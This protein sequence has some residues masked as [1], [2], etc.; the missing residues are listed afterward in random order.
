VPRTRTR[1]GDI[2]FAVAELQIRNSL[3]ADLRLVDNY[4]RF[5][6]H[7]VWLRLRR[8][9]TLVFGRRVQIYLLTYLLTY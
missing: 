8:L 1:L 3:P 6:G 9:V 2:S 4:A 7:N 5:R